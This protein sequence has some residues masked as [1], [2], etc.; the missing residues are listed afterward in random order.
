MSEID[1]L[2]LAVQIKTQGLDELKKTA[3][4]ARSLGVESK[5]QAANVAA[6]TDAINKQAGSGKGLAASLEAIIQASG[7]YSEGVRREAAATL[8]KTDANNKLAI[9]YFQSAQAALAAAKQAQENER[10]AKREEEQIRREIT[11]QVQRTEN[12]RRE[13]EKRRK[14]IEDEQR[15]SSQ[16]TIAGVRGALSSP[17][18]FGLTSI[19]GFIGTVGQ[20]NVAAGAAAAAV[21][22]LAEKSYELVRSNA[23]A[24]R[25]TQNFA[26]RLGLTVTQA[27]ELERVAQLA[28][29]NI[30][31]LEGA[32]RFLGQALE[33]S[34]G[35][36]KRQ[37]TALQKLGIDTEGLA[38][39]E[40]ALGRTLLQVLDKLSQIP[41]KAE[42]VTEAQRVLGRGSK[43]ILPLIENYEQY[44]QTLEKLGV[45]FDENAIRKAA[46]A[47]TKFKEL[48][49]A[50]GQLKQSLA[51]KIQP[52]VIPIIGQIIKI[53]SGQAGAGA[54]TPF[55][56][57]VPGIGTALGLGVSA[58]QGA[59]STI[60]YDK[61]ALQ[62]GY[63]Y[64][65][66]TKPP[67]PQ[68]IISGPEGGLLTQQIV[69]RGK[70]EAERYKNQVLVN[71]PEYIQKQISDLKTRQ[72]TLLFGGE[73]E[74]G[75]TAPGRMSAEQLKVREAE[76]KTNDAR[77]TGLETRLK[78][79]EQAR[80]RAEQ[81]A[82]ALK[83]LAK[84][85]A[86]QFAQSVFDDGT[87]AGKTQYQIFRTDQEKN[88]F[89][90]K[91]GTHRGDRLF[92]AQISAEIGRYRD[93]ERKRQKKAAE[94]LAKADE[95]IGIEMSKHLQDK[96]D[97]RQ[98]KLN[99][100]ETGQ[101]YGP[102]GNIGTRPVIPPP[103]GYVDPQKQLSILKD[104]ETHEQR[105]IQIQSSQAEAVNRIYSL[106]VKYAEQEFAIAMRL[107]SVKA[108]QVDKD[109][110]EAD[111]KA[112]R[113]KAY[114]D[115]AQ[116]REEKLTEMRK[117]QAEQFAGGLFDALGKKNGLTEFFNSQIH[118]LTKQIFVN[119]TKAPLEN[120]L[121][122]FAPK[123]QYD[124][125]GNKTF[126][127]KIFSDTVLED[128][129][130]QITPETVSRD[131]NTAAIDKLTATISGQPVGGQS[132]AAAS[133]GT[134]AGV[135]G[136]AASSA[137]AGQAAG[138]AA[139]STIGN[140]ISTVLGLAALGAVA[141]N[142]LF[143]APGFPGPRSI[144]TS[145][146][147]TGGQGSNIS[148]PAGYGS[149]NGQVG[150]DI[151]GAIGLAGVGISA[152]SALGVGFNKSGSTSGIRG[153]LGNFG[154]GAASV[155]K[156]GLPAI[157]NQD[158]TA[159]TIGAVAGTATI[160]TAGIQS[161]IK[162]FSAGGGRGI[163][164][165]IG[166]ITGTAAALDPEPI[167]KGVLMAI[168][169]VSGIVK[170]L[171][172]DP[173]QERA[174]AINEALTA[175]K[176]LAPPTINSEQGFNGQN[177]GTD[178]YGRSI[179]L[180]QFNG[181]NVSQPYLVKDPYTGSYLSVP[182]TYDNNISPSGAVPGPVA[183]APSG[184]GSTTVN[185]TVHALDSQSIIDRSADIG[186]AVYQE[187]NRG[188]ALGLR[189]QQTVL[190]T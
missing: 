162:G 186:Q 146:G 122:S 119:V 7:Q 27:R 61:K 53:T 36:G 180:G 134:A 6:L 38:G 100:K 185:L 188:G 104:Q 109:K 18:G 46:E 113:D 17:G 1:S 175:Q 103:P 124:A 88:D 152:A 49:I 128:K 51:E 150:R 177:L 138:Q 147:I 94:E 154:A 184:Q 60:P 99:F 165:G 50:F 4:T 178:K 92:D 125:Q 97:Q 42:R 130:K 132:P 35:A 169:A 131:K 139:A 13:T 73:G 63:D 80:H 55:L 129:S 176:Y 12:L 142:T 166:A 144:G 102:I 10:Q 105:M 11:L 67:G 145:G 87:P 174:N 25:E 126:I 32:S 179:G 45:A 149:H 135:S 34:T 117:K 22:V 59:T 20:V 112:L 127:G 108:E 85:T 90:R 156:Q 81:S 62:A 160:L 16:S 123:G 163:A 101:V 24:A 76:Y 107:A 33:D 66:G 114:Y 65:A 40:D 115:A 136:A 44:R 133:T 170:S 31:S 84:K 172:G 79:I 71:D 3:D 68:D 41:N 161:A 111:A 116:E 83:E 37:A 78:L 91:Y 106:K 69:D 95:T 23:A 15:A 74:A 93:E 8:L 96:N 64:F 19:S 140:T 141:G 159:G 21:A 28:S 158:T 26:T 148:F 118:D 153:A 182:G 143:N 57:L 9:S 168:T 110:A 155:T 82:E 54:A 187:I 39:D 173:K 30:Y 183:A 2:Q 43:E 137:A 86:D 89:A 120:I 98:E 72:K 157:W 164:S 48:E 47:N 75:L 58:Y 171:F 70:K 77:L 181:F 190:G 14:L 56:A 189:I 167:S 29:V 5:T 151:A 121:K 52:I